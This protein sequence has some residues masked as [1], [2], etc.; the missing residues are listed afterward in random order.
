[1]FEIP[2]LDEQN[3]LN[4]A[5]ATWSTIVGI[6]SPP[7]SDGVCCAIVLKLLILKERRDLI[8]KFE[9][10]LVLVIWPKDGILVQ[11]QCNVL[12]DHVPEGDGVDNCIR[13]ESGEV[14]VSG[15]NVH[16]LRGTIRGNFTGAGEGIV[17][18]GEADFVLGADLLADDDLVNVVELIPILIERIHIPVKGFKFRGHPGCPC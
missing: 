5:H 10:I 4:P 14:W 1:M 12:G 6:M 11:N 13:I 18:M 17:R 16:I 2:I 8:R 15:A 7:K 3:I 9:I